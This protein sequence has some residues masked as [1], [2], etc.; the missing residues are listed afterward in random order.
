MN[1]ST[2]NWIIKQN[3]LKNLTVL[4]VTAVLTLWAKPYTAGVEKSVLD[5]FFFLSIFPLGAMFA[6]FA[7]SYAETN[8]KSPEHR[9]LADLSTLIF[10]IIICFSV[11]FTTL[12]GILAM[13]QLQ[14]PFIVMAGLLIAGCLIYDFWNLYSNLEKVD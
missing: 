13:P 2:K 6:Y 9:A 11:A 14:L 12:L 1:K 10:L 4:F 8:L 3:I 5:V 7:F